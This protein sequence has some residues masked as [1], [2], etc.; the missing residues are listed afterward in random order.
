MESPNTES[1]ASWWRQLGVDDARLVD[2]FRGFN[3]WAGAFREAGDRCQ[4]AIEIG[5]PR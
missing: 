2:A 3:A 4:A 5:A 1:L